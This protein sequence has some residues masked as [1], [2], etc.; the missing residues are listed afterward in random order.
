MDLR[1]EAWGEAWGDR[2][3]APLLQLGG[4][5]DGWPMEGETAE[6]DLDDPAVCDALSRDVP[7][8]VLA[9]Q[10]RLHG[11][12]PRPS[13]RPP[14]SASAYAAGRSAASGW[15]AQGLRNTVVGPVRDAVEVRHMG[16]AA[17]RPL[18]QKAPPHLV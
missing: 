6:A 12:D 8:A 3:L 14:S 9:L 17:C 11:A 13:G 16:I 7:D 5:L 4:G 2:A 1:P 10:A 18:R 15:A